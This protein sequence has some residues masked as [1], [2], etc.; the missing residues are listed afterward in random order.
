MVQ[1][2]LPFQFCF[3]QCLKFNPMNSDQMTLSVEILDRERKREREMSLSVMTRSILSYLSFILSPFSMARRKSNTSTMKSSTCTSTW[4]SLLGAT[5][6]IIPFP[7]SKQLSSQKSWLESSHRET[8]P[9]HIITEKS[10]MSYF[11]LTESW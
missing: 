6:L 8:S 4:V 7:W 1:Y 2:F 9:Y 11:R 3:F 5:F 10:S